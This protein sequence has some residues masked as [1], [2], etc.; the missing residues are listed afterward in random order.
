VVAY[1]GSLKLSAKQALVTNQNIQG[2]KQAGLGFV[3]PFWHFPLLRF[4]KVISCRLTNQ[5]APPRV[6]SMKN[7]PTILIKARELKKAIK[8]P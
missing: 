1:A 7:S 6:T 3:S 8:I 2:R 5:D 4:S